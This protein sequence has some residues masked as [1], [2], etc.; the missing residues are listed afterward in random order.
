MANETIL[1]A[2]GAGYIGTH[3]LVALYEAGYNA[4]CVDN[5][6]NSS[7]EAMKRVEEIVGTSIPFYEQDVRDTAALNRVFDAHHIDGVINFD[8]P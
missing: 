3:T 2:G 7:P 8:Q 5:F 1:V 4:V 6:D